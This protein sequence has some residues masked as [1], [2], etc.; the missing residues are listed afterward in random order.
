MWKVPS[1]LQVFFLNPERQQRIEGR[2]RAALRLLFYLLCRSIGVLLHDVALADLGVSL[3]VYID[4][5]R[6]DHI[7]AGG[8]VV[9]AVPIS[10]NRG[11]PVKI[12]FSGP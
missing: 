10:V 6:A 4:F 2:H 7:G 11:G 1:F 5:V 8:V 3:G 9:D 12:V